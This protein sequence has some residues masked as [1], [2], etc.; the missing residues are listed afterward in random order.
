MDYLYNDRT[1]G[2]CTPMDKQSAQQTVR[3]L[4]EALP[5]IRAF[6]G[7]SIVIKYGGNAM[8]DDTLKS[9][10]ARDLVLMQQ[11]GL[12]PVVVHGGGPQIGQHLQQI[13][14]KTEFVQGLR[15]TDR[16]TMDIVERVLGDIVNVEIVKLINDHGGQ[17]VGVTG[18]QGGFIHSRKLEPKTGPEMTVPE[19]IDLGHVGEVESI[20]PTPILQLEHENKIPVIAPIGVGD[21]GESYNINADTVASHMAV[22]LKAEKLMLLTNQPGVLDAKGQL[23]TGLVP[24]QISA[25]MEDGTIHG[26]MLPKIRCALEAL[27]AEVHTAHIIDGREPHA[28]LLEIF[29]REGIGTLI[30]AAA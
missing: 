26:G 29:T 23:L 2:P 15:V 10:F 28:V 14:K 12:Q 4:F 3:I 1:V 24:E 21:D 18:K 25:L 16:E 11:V 19:I 20:D 22:A 13:G 6:S 17:A 9:S 5:Y 27:A 7:D 8:I 30:T